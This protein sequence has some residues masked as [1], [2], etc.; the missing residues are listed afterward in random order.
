VD[1]LPPAEMKGLET[2]PISEARVTA[3]FMNNRAAEALA[4]QRTDDAYWWIR[5]GVAADPSFSTLYNTLGVT[6]LRKGLLPRAESALRYALSIAPDSA[7]SWNNL[8]LVLRRD[9]R[10]EQAAAVEREHPRTRAAALAAAIDGGIRANASGDYGRALELFNRVLRTSS[11]SHQ[12][13]YLLAVTYLNLGDR[14]RAMEH[15]R[16]AEDYSLTARQ[17]S[18]YASK[19]ELLKSTKS[20]FRLDPDVLQPN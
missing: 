15:L 1:F 12:I 5:G 2:R 6:Y 11:D 9:G 10:G 20:R 18:V 3:M 19:I 14:R 4:H 7:E 17:R 16:E 8:A 13:H